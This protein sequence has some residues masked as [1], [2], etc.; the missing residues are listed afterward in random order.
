MFRKDYHQSFV[1]PELRAEK[2]KKRAFSGGFSVYF[3]VFT[4]EK[5]AKKSA[6]NPG[7]Q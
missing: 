5:D 3:P 1:Q 4:A 7:Y 6:P 2:E